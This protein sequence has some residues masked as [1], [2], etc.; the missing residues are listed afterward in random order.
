MIQLNII[1]QMDK[2]KNNGVCM[3]KINLS[4]LEGYC[5]LIE[6]NNY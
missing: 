3:V 2:L 6:L 4:L 1:K 5:F